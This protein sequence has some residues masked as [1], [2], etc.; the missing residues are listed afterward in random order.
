[1]T[2]THIANWLKTKIEASGGIAPG[3]AGDQPQSVGVY[4]VQQEPE[5]RPQRV[6]IGGAGNTTYQEMEVILQIRWTEDAAASGQQAQTIYDLFYGLSGIDMDG[7]HLISA[8]PGQQIQWVGR[9]ANNLCE[10]RIRATLRYE[11][12]RS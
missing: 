6:C 10:Y 1:M 12:K 2:E 4:A 7:I 8:D 11:R 9:D 5:A 3:N